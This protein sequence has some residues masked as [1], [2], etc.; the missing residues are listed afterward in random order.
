VP[1]C[2]LS[3]ILPQF[4]SQHR[5]PLRVATYLTTAS[6]VQIQKSSVTELEPPSSPLTIVR[7]TPLREL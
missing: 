2:D 5:I 6:R 4:Y 1:L 3:G 7:P